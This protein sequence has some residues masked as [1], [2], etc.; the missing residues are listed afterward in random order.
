MSWTKKYSFFSLFE[1]TTAFENRE[2]DFSHQEVGDS[3]M[4]WEK[5]VWHL[6]FL[7]E[8]KKIGE[9]SIGNWLWPTLLNIERIVHAVK[10]SPLPNDPRD[11]H[12]PGKRPGTRYPSPE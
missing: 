10:I 1:A 8:S 3:P 12:G 2:G 6:I 9:P 5:S 7:R 11:R 4:S